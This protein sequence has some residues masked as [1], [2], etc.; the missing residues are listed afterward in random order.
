M[1]EVLKGASSAFAIRVLGTLIGFIVSVVVARLLG[2]EGAG[3]YFLAISIASVAAMVGRIGFD[4]TVVRFVASLA[5][6]RDWAGV[7]FV[8]GTASGVVAAASLLISVV[9]FVGAKWLAVDIFGKPIMETPFRIAA[10]SVLPLSLAMIQAESLRGLKSIPASQWIK[11]VLISLGTLAFLYPLVRTRGANGA[12]AAYTIATA[13]TALIAWALWRRA[14][15]HRCEPDSGVYEQ[16]S[17]KRLFRSSWPLFGVALTGLV[18]QQAGTVFL[19]IWRTTDAVGVFNVA[20]RIANLLLFPLIA[21]ISIIT[22][23]FAEMHRQ[24][25]ISGMQKLAVSSSRILTLFALPVSIGFIVASDWI[26]SLFGPSFAGGAI[27]LQVLIVGVLVNAATG[28]VSEILMMTGHE[29]DCRNVN[30]A[31]A[32]SLVILCVALI[33]VYG[34]VGAAIAVTIGVAIKNLLMVYMTHKRLG[35][36]PVSFL[37]K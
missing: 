8:N 4:N 31:G 3:V 34:A 13:F 19:G 10:L 22:P 23:K 29:D 27:I 37:A 25:D 33:P 26:L 28:A 5:S 18:I 11:T 36:W 16:R 2:A 24:S 14:F 7:R 6:A 32:A 15:R 30:A 17:V 9:F 1:R 21:M 20:S 35:F 12:V